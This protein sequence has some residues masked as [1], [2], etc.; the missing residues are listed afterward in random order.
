MSANRDPA[1]IL[2]QIE[3]TRLS[4]LFHRPRWAST[5]LAQA[6]NVPWSAGHAGVPEEVMG[7]ISFLG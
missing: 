6:H 5:F 7:L 2:D 4:R 1:Q 3:H